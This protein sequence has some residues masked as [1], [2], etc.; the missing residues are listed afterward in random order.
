MAM[1][2]G[3]N[4]AGPRI[5]LPD[6]RAFPST[7]DLTSCQATLLDFLCLQAPWKMCGSG[8]GPLGHIIIGLLSIN[9]YLR[10]SKRLCVKGF[11]VL[12]AV[13]SS[14]HE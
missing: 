1:Q 13:V 14:T 11:S 4:R 12:F 9:H 6:P 5:L 3:T 2:T 8:W 10:R 7:F